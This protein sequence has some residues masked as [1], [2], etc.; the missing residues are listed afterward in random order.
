MK[1][2]KKQKIEKDSH[3]NQNFNENYETT[4][5]IRM[6]TRIKRLPK[7]LKDYHCNLNVFNAFSRVKYP[8]NSILSYNK[9]S[10][11]YKSFVMSL[12]SHVEPNTYS[13]AVKHDCWRKAIQCE[14]S[15]LES[16]QTWETALLA[17]NKTIIGCKWVFKIKYK[18][19][20]TVEVA[21]SKK[22]IMMNQK[23]YALELL[24]GAD[25]LACKPAVSLWIILLNC[26]LLEVYLSKCLC[27]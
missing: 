5:S 21:R 10:P 20:E 17:K 19:G 13:E 14:I 23:K 16:N 8:S 15:V 22:G 3:R 26:L 27:L 2:R 25:L 12:S 4:Q 7:Y 18:A 11:S 1:K 9:L 6:S 24:T